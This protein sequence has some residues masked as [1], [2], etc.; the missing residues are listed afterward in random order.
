MNTFFIADTHFGDEKIL[1]YENRPFESA[2]QMDEE[3][4][5]RWNRAVGPEDTVF[6]LGDFSADLG[7]AR[8]RE[9]L[10]R[11]NGKKVLVLGNHDRHRTPEEWRGLGF[12]E[13]APWPILFGGFFL[14]SHEPV[15]VNQNMPYANLYG[16]VHGNPSYRDAS[17]QSVCV[18]AER[19]EYA[20]LSFERVRELLQTFSVHSRQPVL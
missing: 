9:L 1:R 6:H 2:E 16:H 15:Y 11:L 17:P 3:L 5:R 19:T 12:A 18:S 8:D 10:G 13:A 4:A 7:A 20:P 14:L